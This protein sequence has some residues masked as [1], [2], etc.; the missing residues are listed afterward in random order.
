MKN[1]EG[2]SRNRGAQPQRA[3]PARYKKE[4]LLSTLGDSLSLY[5]L[6]T[7][8]LPQS[9]DR[10]SLPRGRKKRLKIQTNSSDSISPKKASCKKT[11]SIQKKIKV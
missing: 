11:A 3:M 5:C 10:K 1:T 4:P 8:N 9:K 7:N 2:L 6:Y